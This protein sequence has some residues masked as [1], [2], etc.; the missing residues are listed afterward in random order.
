MLVQTDCGADCEYRQILDL[1][2]AINLAA[3]PGG[4]E[5]PPGA[6]TDCYAAASDVQAG[7]SKERMWVAA[8]SRGQTS[9]SQ[10]V[11]GESRKPANMWHDV[12]RR[13]RLRR[14]G[15]RLGFDRNPMRRGSDQFQAVMRAGLL[16]LFLVGAPAAAVQVG[17]GVYVSGLRAGR[18]QTAAWHRVP[19]IVLR[20]APMTAGWLRPRPSPVVLSVRWVLPGGVARTGEI[21]SGE[22]RAAGSILP[23]WID[24]R[25]RLTHPPQSRLDVV[26]QAI[27]AGAVT[28]AV[29]AL[30]LA[31]VGGVI[32]R[33]LDRYRL[34]RWAEDWSA[35]EPQWTGRR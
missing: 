23:V 13:G 15:R 1:V 3:S 4:L 10:S 8:A 2:A 22:K 6:V 5:G 34:A 17:D 20:A 25:G 18:A 19:A 33:L 26:G 28:S 24:A 16:V 7:C 11:L 12:A 31:A 35:V 21:T 27:G 30:V 14:F 9:G 29:L 32:S